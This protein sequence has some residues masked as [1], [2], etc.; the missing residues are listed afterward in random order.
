M[1]LK[2]VLLNADVGMNRGPLLHAIALLGTSAV[3]LAVLVG[4]TADSALAA[5]AELSRAAASPVKSFS[6]SSLGLSQTDN[7]PS[8][9]LLRLSIELHEFNLYQAE[10]IGASALLLCAAVLGAWAGGLL[11]RKR[12]WKAR[13][14][15]AAPLLALS[16]LLVL[17]YLDMVIA[18]GGDTV[19]R[20]GVNALAYPLLMVK[21]ELLYNQG[22]AAFAAFSVALLTVLASVHILT[23]KTLWSFDASLGGV[24]VPAVLFLEDRLLTRD[25]G[26]MGAQV[27]NYV[28]W[29][30]NWDVLYATLAL[31]ATLCALTV[32]VGVKAGLG[33]A[34]TRGSRADRRQTPLRATDAM[35]LAWQSL[36]QRL[37]ALTQEFVQ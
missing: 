19:N 28:H 27:M 22:L 18:D 3:F 1:A 15:F 33:W 7:L 29:L 37:V 26:D 32:F 25:P 4:L 8:S 17:F 21:G 16:A 6:A 2:T 34:R 30:T 11:V 13:L 5:L 23:G 24:G 14:A 10:L 9:Q 35:G 31:G 36:W 20:F 12:G